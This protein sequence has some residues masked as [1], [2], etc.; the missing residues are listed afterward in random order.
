MWR[1][2][3]ASIYFFYAGIAEASGVTTVSLQTYLQLLARTA[4][5]SGGSMVLKKNNFFHIG[6]ILI[7]P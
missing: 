5:L 2:K 4:A 6:K 3:T 1:M 7:Y